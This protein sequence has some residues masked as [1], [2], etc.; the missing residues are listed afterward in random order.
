VLDSHGHTHVGE[1]L[2]ERDDILVKQADATLAGTAGDGV[3]VVGAA[4]DADTLVAGRLEAQEPVSVSQDVATSVLEVVLP[5]RGILNHGDFEG[6]A[7]P[8]LGGAHVT[9]PLLVALVLAHAAGELGHDDGVARCIAVIHAQR[10][11]VLRDNDKC[12]AAGFVGQ[13][14]Q[15]QRR[16]G[17]DSVAALFNVVGSLSLVGFM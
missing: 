5:C 2:L 9:A 4:V 10:H 8:G 16:N 15:L 11:V 17:R 3:L 14:R 1:M 13:G 12:R 6:L 7:C